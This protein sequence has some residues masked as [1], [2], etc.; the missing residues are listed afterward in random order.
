MLPYSSH[1]DD[2][3]TLAYSIRPIKLNDLFESKFDSECASDVEIDIDHKLCG[4]YGG[5][6]RVTII[7]FVE[8]N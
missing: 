8:D 5:V 4:K 7:I 1:D 6:L 3:K 2:T